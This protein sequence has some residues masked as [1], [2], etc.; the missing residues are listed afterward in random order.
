MARLEMH[1]VFRIGHGQ[2][3]DLVPVSCSS[4]P[5]VCARP[6]GLLMDT[7]HAVQALDILICR[8]MAQKSEHRT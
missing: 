4:P 6:Y 1:P 7:E 3:R 2:L 5:T 8:A